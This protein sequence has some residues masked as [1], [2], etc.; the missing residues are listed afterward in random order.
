MHAAAYATWAQA[1]NTTVGPRARPHPGRHEQP[2]ALR[3]WC[4][5]AG[6]RTGR[7]SPG[8]SRRRRAAGSSSRWPTGSTPRCST[9]CSGNG[10]SRDCSRR[11]TPP[12]CS[13][14]TPAKLRD[15]GMPAVARRPV[16]RRCP[17]GGGRR[18]GRGVPPR[19]ARRRRSTPRPPSSPPRRTC[20]PRAVDEHRAGLDQSNTTDG[21]ADLDDLRAAQ[22]ERLSR[23]FPHLTVVQANTPH[24]AD[25][26]EAPIVS[27]RQ[28]GRAR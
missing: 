10:A 3:G 25:K 22:A 16:R 18:G 12:T 15:T 8:R 23:T 7:T 17:P 14:P 2:A 13:P 26:R 27:P 9:S 28:R 24:L 19:R 20:P 6:A 1:D 5:R 4:W 21:A 11:P